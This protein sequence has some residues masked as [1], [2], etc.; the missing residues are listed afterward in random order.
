MDIY[1]EI[2]LK[3]EKQGIKI[4]LPIEK[5]I[6]HVSNTY[7]KYES[8]YYDKNQKSLLDSIPYWIKAFSYININ[9]SKNDLIKVLDYGCGTGFATLQLINSEL[10]DKCVEI[11]CFDP[12]SDM[13]EK[14][15]KNVEITSHGSKVK[16]ISDSNAIHEKLKLRQ[17]D[18]IM[19]N[20]LLHH[21]PDPL[22]IV[23]LFINSLNSK[24]F[25]ICG[26]E[27]NKSF[28]FNDVLLNQ[29]KNFRRF[30]R[31][32]K[33]LGYQYIMKKFG[34]KKGLD[35]I[36]ATNNDLIVVGIISRPLPAN[37]LVKLI[38]IHVPIGL[39]KNQYWGELGFSRKLFLNSKKN[40]Q[41]SIPLY[42]TYSHIKDSFVNEFRYWR[43]KIK[44][45]AFQYPDDG[46]DFLAVI[47]IE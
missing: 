20:S 28:Y 17:Y 47:K 40:K 15:K 39:S 44:K 16:Y 37:Y 42:Y 27:P 41:I 22:G 13:L 29:T 9:L 25:Y 7:H 19:T 6:E 4:N 3:L 10:I 36:H 35:I 24:R 26:H 34:F 18:L 12:S 43:K 46:A 8:D 23:N 5:F 38:D 45:L 30:K 11:C 33:R 32:Y 21:I 31:I 14:C 2:A 1:S